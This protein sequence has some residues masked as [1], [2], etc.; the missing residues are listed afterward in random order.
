MSL[1]YPGLSVVPHKIFFS[2][3]CTICPVPRADPFPIRSLYIAYG[4]HCELE[5]QVSLSGDSGTI[6]GG[7]LKRLQDGIEEVERMFKGGVMN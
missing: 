1:F 2:F 4:S 3:S 7:K 5:T 6:E